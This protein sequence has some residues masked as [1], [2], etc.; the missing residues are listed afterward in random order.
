MLNRTK[1]GFTLI[2]LL[3]VI[4]IIGVLSSITLTQLNQSRIKGADASIKSNLQNMRSVAENLYDALNGTNGFNQVCTT[5]STQSMY[6]T[7]CSASLGGNCTQNVTG[8]CTSVVGY[9]VS[10]VQLKS[11]TAQAWCVDNTGNSKQIPKPV[12]AITVCP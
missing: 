8:Q 7:A 5:A 12:G 10:W 11:N 2:E 3:V 4:A 1:K 6:N 9:W